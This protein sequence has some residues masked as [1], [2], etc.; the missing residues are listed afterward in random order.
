MGH[1]DKIVTWKAWEHIEVLCGTHLETGG[2]RIT[3]EEM[4]TLQRGH[5]KRSV[6]WMRTEMCRMLEPEGRT[7]EHSI[8]YGR[9]CALTLP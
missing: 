6:E 7:T 3:L 5:A 9:R 1:T 2:R 4:G 8:M